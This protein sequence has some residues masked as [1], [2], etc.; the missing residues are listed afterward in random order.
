MRPAGLKAKPVALQNASAD[1]AQASFSPA[2]AIDGNPA[3][4]QGWAVSPE[5]GKPH[6]A[7]FETKEN[8]PAGATLTLVMEQ[9]WGGQH[10]IGRFRLSATNAPRPVKLESEQPSYPAEVAQILAVPAE[11]RTRRAASAAGRL[12]RCARM[13]SWRSSSKPSPSTR[14]KRRQSRLKGAQD[15]AWA[16]INTPAFLFN[17]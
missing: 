15:L 1:F 9:G 12:L 2:L 13:P 16:L 17:R 11:Q 4:K 3:P 5:F 6:S 14:S 8:L 10:T 7:V